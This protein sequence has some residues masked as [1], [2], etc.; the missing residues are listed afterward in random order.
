MP[1]EY[2]VEYAKSG[3][4]RCRLTGNSIPNKALRIGELVENDYG[5]APAWMNFDDFEN[6]YASVMRF[7]NKCGDKPDGYSSLK[8]K[9]KQRVNAILDGSSRPVMPLGYVEPE[10]EEDE[11]EDEEEN[12]SEEEEESYSYRRRASKRPRIDDSQRFSTMA[13]PQ[14][15]MQNVQNNIAPSILSSLNQLGQISNASSISSMNQGSLPPSFFALPPKTNNEHQPIMF[16]APRPIFDLLDGISEST[17]KR[18]KSTLKRPKT[19]PKK[20]SAPT[21]FISLS[22]AEPFTTMTMPDQ[23]TSLESMVKR[24]TPTE[25][26]LLLA[27]I[28]VKDPGQS[29]AIKSNVLKVIESRKTIKA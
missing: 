4:S 15:F 14:E 24:M 28:V 9:D 22:N 19:T 27:R 26:Q 29:E 6:D 17:P 16:D 5:T 1:V 21:P 13:D 23:N 12:E 7:V 3:R 8:P 18:P 20:V 25:L 11:E 2:Q 10:E